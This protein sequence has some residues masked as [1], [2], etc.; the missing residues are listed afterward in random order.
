MGSGPSLFAEGSEGVL[1]LALLPLWRLPDPPTSPESEPYQKSSM[2]LIDRSD[3]E[4]TDNG[5]V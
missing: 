3:T 4:F 1:I 5:A 2:Q